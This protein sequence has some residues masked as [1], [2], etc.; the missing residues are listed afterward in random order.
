MGLFLLATLF[1]VVA[2]GIVG[3]ASYLIDKSVERRE[4]DGR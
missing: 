3:A 2:F 4:R 1:V